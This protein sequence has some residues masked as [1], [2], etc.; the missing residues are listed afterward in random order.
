MKNI[1]KL[2]KKLFGGV[3]KLWKKGFLGKVTVIFGA[4]I[5]L[6]LFTPSSSENSTTTTTLNSIEVTPEENF[7]NIIENNFKDG[8][9]DIILGTAIKVDYYYDGVSIEKKF[10]SNIYKTLKELKD[11]EYLNQAS[12]I[13]FQL[14]SDLID[15]YGNS[16]KDYVLKS[17]F[18]VED[19]NKTNFDNLTP[20]KFYD[21]IINWEFK[22]PALNK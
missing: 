19:I 10:K 15:T 22:H 18:K 14:K 16:K 1:K 20:E 5:L 2:F 8:V 3:K 4:I 6:F 9:E 21:N 13:T 7:K 17:E 12:T 11:N